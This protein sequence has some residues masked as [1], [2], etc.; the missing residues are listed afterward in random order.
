MFSK[1]YFKLKLFNSVLWKNE[2][3]YIW[4]LFYLLIDKCQ[5][6]QKN[7][8]S[9][10]LKLY[11]RPNFGDFCDIFTPLFCNNFLYKNKQIIAMLHQRDYFSPFQIL[12]IKSMEDAAY[13]CTCMTQTVSLFCYKAR[14][15]VWLK[16]MRVNFKFFFPNCVLLPDACRVTKGKYT[17]CWGAFLSS[18]IYLNGKSLILTA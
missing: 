3:K 5:W 4:F 6:F 7:Y 9:N 8:H 13:I 16:I 10:G 1:K 17:G 11:F 15:R 14:E 2:V 18:N 12:E